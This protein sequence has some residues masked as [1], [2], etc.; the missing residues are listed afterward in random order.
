MKNI[1]SHFVFN[2]QQRN[3]IFFLLFLIVLFQCIYFFVIPMNIGISPN[4]NDLLK[5]NKFIAFQKQIDSL[6]QIESKKKEFQLFPFNPNYLNDYKGY[7]LGM[8]NEQIDKLIEYRERGLFVNSDKEFQK[9]TGV[10][11]SLLNKMS[12]YFKFPEWINKKSLPTIE[13]K[14]PLITKKDLNRVT[15]EDLKKVYGIG[16]KLS[17]RIIKYRDR[18][19]GYTINEQL[20]EVYGLEEKIANAILK[21]YPIETSPEIKKID[22]N[23]ASLKDLSSIIYIKYDLAQNIIEYRSREGKIKNMDE[24]LK[25]EGF[26]PEKISRI[27]LYLMIE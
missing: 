18:L 20:Y 22:V 14:K 27:K 7:S 10:S 4:E 17:E 19:K 3:G 6:K 2:K 24:F 26:T 21:V 16:D 5:D 25:I 23:N 1:K 9:I 11:D 12:P 13:H 15:A 8:T